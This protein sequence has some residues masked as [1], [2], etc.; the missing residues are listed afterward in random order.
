MG[1]AP[2]GAT[3]ISASSPTAMR[4]RGFAGIVSS[5]SAAVMAVMR[6]N[7]KFSIAT[8]YGYDDAD[9]PDDPLL[10]E[11]K[12]MRR[13]LFTWKDWNVI[14]PIEYL[15]PFLRTI[16][17]VET[18]GPITGVALGA[19]LKVLKHGLIDVANAHA[20]DAMHAVADAVTLCR[21]E[22]T[23]ADHD[24]VVLSKILHVLL[25]C[26]TCPAGRLLSD[27]DVCNV[28]QACYRIGHQSGK[29]SA[30]MRNLSR[31][32]L[33]EIV[34]AVFKGLPEMDGLRA[35]D[36]SEDG[37]G[38]TPG[39]AHHIEGKPPPS[40]SKQPA[41]AAALAEGQ[42]P[43][44]APPTEQGPGAATDAAPRSPTH[45]GGH[46]ADTERERAD[47]GGH[48]AELDGGPAGEPFGLMCVLEI[49]RF[50]VSF[51]SLE[52]DADEN[53]EGACAFGLQL[54]LASLE[55][56]GDHFARH[57]PLLELVQDDLCRAVLSVAPAGHPSTLAAVAAVILQLY[58]V[59]HSHLKLQL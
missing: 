51:V 16:R 23:D 2:G 19:V 50:S 47:L 13:K 29:E 14:P 39:R 1:V 38:T 8:G 57:A 22:A 5:E 45:A 18:S 49:F 27:D 21:F 52:R 11:F 48:D 7:A 43:A 4:A 44:P 24:D 59:M 17:S 15:A 25:E 33:R 37:A 20:A 30:L 28:V 42:P 34:H 12:A 54:V 41:A 3:A 31:H 32:I 9:A 26:V 6:Q 56:S 46:A 36:A 55:S 10:E 35:S 40:P 53:A 58:L